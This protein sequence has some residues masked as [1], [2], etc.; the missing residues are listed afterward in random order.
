MKTALEILE[1]AR[2]KITP[3]ENWAQG[4]MAEDSTGDSIDPYDEEACKWCAV[5]ALYA[6]TWRSDMEEPDGDIENDDAYQEADQLLNNIAHTTY[7]VGLVSV[8]D[9]VF[10][11]VDGE[12]HVLVLKL[13]DAAIERIRATA[14]LS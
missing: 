7:G 2:E 1:C 9:G 10:E 3:I 5:G 11:S 12:P 6:C 14:K 8:N 4:H 13:F